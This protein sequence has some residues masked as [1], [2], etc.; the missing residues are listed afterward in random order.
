MTHVFSIAEI[1]GEKELH[2]GWLMPAEEVDVD[3]VYRFL[4]TGPSAI[5]FEKIF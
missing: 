1:N 4:Q 5:T 3:A 2:N